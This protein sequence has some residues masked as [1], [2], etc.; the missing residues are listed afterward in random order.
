MVLVHFMQGF[1]HTIHQSDPLRMGSSVRKWLSTKSF[2]EQY[3]F[4]IKT[5]KELGW[6]P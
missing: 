1:Q 5:L 2:Q 6:T 3:D 4:G